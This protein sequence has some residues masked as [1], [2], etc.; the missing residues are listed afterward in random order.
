M[1]ELNYKVE[2]LNS[3]TWERNYGAREL[4]PLVRELNYGTGDSNYGREELTPSTREQ[5]YETE[6]LLR[7]SSLVK[8]SSSSH[9]NIT[10]NNRLQTMNG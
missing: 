7:S 5:N 8:L 10:P 4:N 2:D 6:E 3:P 1:E 9:L